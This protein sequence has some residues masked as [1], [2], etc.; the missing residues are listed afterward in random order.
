M[1]AIEWDWEKIQ[2]I[3]LKLDSTISVLES[4]QNRLEQFIAQIDGAW[5]SE[6]G[7]LYAERIEEDLLN[8][9]DTVEN[10]RKVRNNLD[11]AKRTYAMCEDSINTKLAGLYSQMSV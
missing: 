8:I 1:A 3:V 6:A 7:S 2:G 5:Q 4:Q 9:K 11:E 10:Y